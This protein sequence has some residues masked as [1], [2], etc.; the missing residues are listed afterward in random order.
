MNT[1][2]KFYLLSVFGTLIISF[3]PLYMGI[4]VVRDM[5]KEG[6]VLAENYP[7]YI[8]PY[9]PISLAII[10]SILLMPIAIKYAKRFSL[11]VM[12]GVSIAVFFVSELLLENKVIVTTNVTT[13]LENWQ[14]LMCYVSPDGYASRTWTAVDVLIGEYSPAFKIHFYI[15]S[16]V[17]ILSF[18]N[19]FYGFAQ[20]IKSGDKRRLKPL[21]LQ[22]ISSVIFLG[23]CVL[24]CFT[25]FFRTGELQVSFISASLMSIFF[26]VF[27]VTMGIYTGSFLL[28]SKKWL[29][30]WFPSAVSAAV[31]LIMYIGELILLSGHLYRFG[32]GFFFDGLG[33]FVFAP[34]DL[35]V[36]LLSGFISSGILTLLSKAEKNRT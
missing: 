26:V 4:C 18:L 32:S 2:K 24:A 23:L 21:I 5:I 12:S 22:A 17:L 15:I 11:L 7:K 20:M 8:I 25:A 34:V 13:T 35:L 36:I 31:T 1:F 10:I 30:V 3:Y 27:G 16:I 28:G 14:M 9:T 19:C 33:D 29:S 6:T